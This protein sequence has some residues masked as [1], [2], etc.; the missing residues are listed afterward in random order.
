MAFSTGTMLE[1]SSS[2]SDFE[3][4]SEEESEQYDVFDSNGN[5]VNLEPNSRKVTSKVP[6]LKRRGHRGKSKH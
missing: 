5:T 3:D 2:L 1:A 6:L 4:I